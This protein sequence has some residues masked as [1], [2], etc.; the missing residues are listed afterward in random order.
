MTSVPTIL[1]YRLLLNDRFRARRCCM[2]RDGHLSMIQALWH[3]DPA[4][5]QL[6]PLSQEMPIPLQPLRVATRRHSN[7]DV[8]KMSR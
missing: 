6:A 5:L 4:A 1:R 3:A 2:T 7:Q 8:M